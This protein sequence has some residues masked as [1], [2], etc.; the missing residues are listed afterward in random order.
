[1]DLSEYIRGSKPISRINVHLKVER[2]WGEA[3][4]IDWQLNPDVNILTGINGSGKST[5]L[6]LFYDAFQNDFTYF[7]GTDVFEKLTIEL[8]ETKTE[9][10]G[11]T[12]LAIKNKLAEEWDFSNYS[13]SL[14]ADFYGELEVVYINTFDSLLADFDNKKQGKSERIK[15]SL[16]LLLY[17]KGVEYVKYLK[18]LEA[19][20]RHENDAT[21]YDAKN[22]FL[23]ILNDSFS[24]TNKQIKEKED[25][26]SFYFEKKTTGKVLSPFQFSAGEKQFFYLLLSAL[27]QNNKPTIFLLD[28]PEISLH[29]EWQLNLIRYIR[30]LNPNAM[31]IAATH[32]PEILINGWSDKEFIMEDLIQP[33]ATIPA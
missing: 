1:M 8:N 20:F 11:K 32:S 12:R 26:S 23:Q 7:E 4:E 5:L 13:N 22:R 16:D 14:A 6:R 21:T 30:E 3:N 25:I 19:K 10:L 33:L 2:L 27:I 18:Q 29:P 15:T 9:F 28:E 17:A 24:A 31:V